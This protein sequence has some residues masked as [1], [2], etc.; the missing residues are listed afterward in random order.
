MSPVR[1]EIHANALLLNAPHRGSQVTASPQVSIVMPLFN[2]E[3]YI[4]AALESCLSQSLRDIEIICVDDA[5]TDS[6]VDIVESFQRRDGRVR[7]IRQPANLSAFQARRIGIAA[8]CAPYVLFVDGDDELAPTAAQ[9]A[10]EAA[11]TKNAD[12]VGFGIEIVTANSM[13]PKRFEAAL[14]PK[15]E[16][17]VAPAIVPSLFP[18]GEVANGHLWRY[19][20]ATSLI[21]SAYHGLDPDLAFYRAN[22]LP[23]TFLA[24]ANARKYVSIRQRLYRY[25]FRRGTSGHAIETLDHFRFLLSGV[26]PISAVEH[27]V[28]VATSGRPDAPEVLASY[29][30]ARLHIVASVL[31]N[32][33]ADTSGELQAECLSLLRQRAG[34]LDVVRAAAIFHPEALAP[35]SSNFDEPAQT[36]G[37][38]RSILMTTA[39]LDTGG[40]QSVVLDHVS[41]FTEAGYH[42][43]I[44]VL[45]DT[46]REL[47]LPTGVEVVVL[48]GSTAARIDTLTATCRDHA[49]D[50]IIDHHILYN[51]HWPWFALAGLAINV[52][53][54]GWVHNFSLRPI[55]DHS[56]RAS[57]L[58]NHG[59]LLLKIV[60]LSPT[61]VA[62]WKLQGLQRAVH[63]PNPPSQL[64]LNALASNPE[65]GIGERIELAWWG[66]LDG[67][68]KQVKD[69]I[70]IAA[71]L[72]AKGV[73]YRLKII[74]PDSKNLSASELLTLAVSAGV[75]D[76]VEIVGE[77]NSTDLIAELSDADL[78]VSTSAIE[79][80]QLTIV[81]AQALGM[82]VVMY[83][84][85]W[86][87][88][89]SGN[90]GIV[91]TTPG[92]PAEAADAIASLAHDPV[93]YSQLSAASRE[94][95][96]GV[97]AIDIQDLLVRLVNDTLPS[98]ASP[99]PSL[100]DARILVHWLTLYAERASRNAPRGRSGGLR[101]LRKLHGQ[102]QHIKAGPSY[103]IGRALTYVPRRV[104]AIFSNSRRPQ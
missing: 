11:R 85:P 86:L 58:A 2:D 62:Y 84:L 38:V 81:E 102:L 90:A 92:D 44:A 15:F 1:I 75:D 63:L 70:R 68:T 66:R 4:A 37:D 51:E 77:L 101:E 32:C 72:K 73:Q 7:L 26:D 28:E 29:E 33:I 42:V 83:D 98:D 10:L 67:P 5:S 34:D 94:F 80:Y 49:V 47:N 69:L 99:E 46:E 95:A 97:A 48:E 71:E 45:R 96:R 54:I 14:Q 19:L 103:R 17:L 57:F 23:I 64:M 82:P 9:S 89:V 50:L 91:A 59:R 100:G 21:R 52:P 65:G 55:F 27:S 25:H 31:R 87:A 3:D 12:V 41:R 18:V 39:H 40:L 76:A 61:D 60:T 79:G 20:F 74:G 43:T 36:V 24:L 78:L 104:Q 35:L 93:R 6:T 16:E 88:T 13:K 53:M 22:D 8:A 30:S 56:Q